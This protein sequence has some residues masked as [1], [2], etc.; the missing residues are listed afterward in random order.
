MKWIVSNWFLIIVLIAYITTSFVYVRKMYMMPSDEQLK[1]VRQWLLWAVVA[2]EKELGAKTGQLKLRYV[3]DLFIT[4]FPLLVDIIS[5]TQFSLL[6]DEALEQ[7]RHL[8]ET[9]DSIKAYT[10]E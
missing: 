2:A 5:F 3:Y 9:N 1:K 6:V 4:K 10:E 8:I 7:M